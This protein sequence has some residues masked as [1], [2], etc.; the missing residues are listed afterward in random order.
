MSINLMLVTSN[1]DSI[2]E[3][4]EAGI[5]RIFFDL[6]YINKAER[7]R[8]R[9]TLILH[10]D[11]EDILKLRKIVTK[12][13]LLVR[14]NALYPYSKEEIDKAISY[15]ADIIM[16]PMVIDAED[17][18]TLVKYVDKRAKVMPMIETA[19]SVARIDDIL[20]IEGI[21]EIFIGLNDLHIS[22]GL[23][24]MFELLSGGIV[25]Y[26]SEKIT[27]KGIKF[28]FGGMARIGEGILPAECILAEHYR[29]KSSSV[30]LSRTFRNEVGEN[31]EKVDLISEVSKIR[32]QE[33]FIKTWKEEDFESNKLFVKEKVKEIIDLI[34]S[35]AN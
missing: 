30:I 10:N 34:N 33:E 31:R 14:V 27:K 11:I 3:A 32:K 5:D 19:Q 24:F 17:V 25:E 12:S 6:E 16:L 21:D 9:D 26:L 22:M 1:P 35:K 18:R 23:T 8:G 29:L 4:Q 20:E 28:G 13:E 15:G 2:I 7:Q